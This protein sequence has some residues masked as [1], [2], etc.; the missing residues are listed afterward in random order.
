MRLRFLIWLHL[1]AKCISIKWNSSSGKAGLVLVVLV[2][3][4]SGVGMTKAWFPG[5]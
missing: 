4:D 1:V 5:A 2:E 3:T